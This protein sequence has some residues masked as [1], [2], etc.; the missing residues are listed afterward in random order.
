MT[1][2]AIHQ[3]EYLPCL[4]LLGKIAQADVL[5]L[6][7]DVQFKR[8]SLQQRA[9]VASPE[10]RGRWL[11]IPFV[12]RHPQLIREVQVADPGWGRKH[13]DIVKQLY[14]D[15]PYYDRLV[16]LV[17]VWVSST[18]TSTSSVSRIACRTMDVLRDVFG[19]TQRVELSSD[20]PVDTDDKSERIVRLC[21]AV[22]G[23]TYLCGQSGASYLDHAPFHA[24]GIEIVVNRY[25]APG[26]YR[27]D[28]PQETHRIS[29]LDAM[30]WHPD[31]S[32]LVPHSL[33]E[34]S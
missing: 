7:D 23:T 25:Q 24:A 29:G 34:E 10:G 3:P 9:W 21:Q 13:F 26:S 15:A 33:L 19:A 22:G 31:P 20:I 18:S 1:V 2:V 30:L 28:C 8:D 27:Q 17:D 14:R 11:T 4:T 5:I 16:Q 12:H 6:L 32:S